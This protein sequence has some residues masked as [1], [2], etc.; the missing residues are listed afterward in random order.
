MA[1]AIPPSTWQNGFKQPATGQPWVFDYTEED[2]VDDDPN[3]YV[4]PPSQEIVTSDVHNDL[5]INVIRTWPTIYNG[6]NSPHGIPSWWQPSELVDVLI[7][8]G[9]D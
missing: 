9:K 1:F 5:G 8:G 3:A 4:M 7:S 2:G 6:T